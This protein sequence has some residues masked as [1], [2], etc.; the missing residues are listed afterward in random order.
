MRRHCR[1][2]AGATRRLAEEENQRER[3]KRQDHQQLE[4]IDIGDDLRLRRDRG[5]ERGAPR[6]RIWAPSPKPL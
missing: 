5:I 4:I 3:D 6:R 2:E 1:L